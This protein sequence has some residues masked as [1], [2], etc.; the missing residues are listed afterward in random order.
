MRAIRN[1]LASR[2]LWLERLL[3]AAW[4]KLRQYWLRLT[5][6]QKD[7]KT[8]PTRIEKGER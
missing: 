5:Q 8:F 6:R 1:F 7:E 4:Q 2:M 3:Q